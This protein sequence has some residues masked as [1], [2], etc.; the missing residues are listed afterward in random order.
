[1]NSVLADGRVAFI[2]ALLCGCKLLGLGER[3]AQAGPLILIVTESG[4]PA[5]SVTDNGGLDNDPRVGVINTNTT[6]LNLSLLNY[7]FT[8]L[9]ARSNSPGSPNPRGDA[10]LSQTG[11]VELLVG[12][13]GSVSVVATNNEYSNP[14]G[15]GFLHSSASNTYTDATNGNSTV[16]TSWFNQSNIL[17]GMDTASP[18]VTFIAKKPPDPNSH[19]DNAADTKVD[20]MAPFG[21]TDGMLI[22]L[23]GGTTG[24]PAQDQFTGSTTVNATAIPEPASAVLML[25]AVPVAIVL[26]LR[27]RN[28]RR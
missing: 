27:W 28:S 4:G 14:T 16:F 21:L 25:S 1:M 22:T 5:I 23:T 13:T 18:A 19:S 20:V 26:Y 8:D 24:A 9:E 15:A 2:A 7:K 11:A 3:E 6:L 12:G 10:G 17:G